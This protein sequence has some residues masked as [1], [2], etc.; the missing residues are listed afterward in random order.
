MAM[1]PCKFFAQGSCRNGF[2]CHFGHDRNLS[3][4]NHSQPVHSAFPAIER[5]DITSGTANHLD[6]GA[7]TARICT[8]FMQGSCNKADKCRYLHPSAIAPSEQNHPDVISRNPY[9]D[10]RRR[11]PQELSDSRASIPCRFLSRPGGC[12]NDPCPFL[13]D[14][15]DHQIN[16]R[17]SQDFGPNDDKVRTHFTNSSRT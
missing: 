6:A 5:L 14:V 7:K 1:T 15:N 12:Q 9:Q 4:Q 3:S 10:Q 2:S 16:R 13:H 11:S 8:F 17:N